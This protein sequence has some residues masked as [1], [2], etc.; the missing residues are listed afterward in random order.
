MAT[1]HTVQE[2]KKQLSEI[3]YDKL[4]LPIA[5]GIF[6]L[7]VLRNAWLAEDAFI[8]FRTVDNFIHGHGLRWNIAERVQTYTHPL[9]MLLISALY[10]ITRE[11][12]YTVIA[13]ATTTSLAA[14]AISC[15][16]LTTPPFNAALGL[17]LL[18]CSKAFIDF[19]TSGLENPLTHL[20]LA[21]FIAIYLTAERNERTLFRL[22]LAAGLA[23][24]NRMDT[25]L[26]LLPALCWVWWPQRGWH[27]AKSAL[28]GFAPF[29]CWPIFSLWYYGFPL[30]NTAYAKLN[31]GIPLSES[32]QRGI[33]FLSSSFELDP[34][35]LPAITLAILLPLAKRAWRDLPLSLG[36]ML[37][38]L[39]ILRIGGDFM[40]GRFL[41]APL[42]ISAVLIA[43]H[44]LRKPAHLT[45]AI[46]A[47]L[48]ASLATPRSPL[49]SGADYGRDIAEL[50][51]EYRISDERGIFYPHTGLLPLL[52][53]E[54]KKHWWATRSLQ[55]K[56][57]GSLQ[58]TTKEGFLV[59]PPSATGP[60][61]TT[62]MNI[63]LSGF[64]AGPDIHI[65]DAMALGD[66]LLARLPALANP[67]WGPGHFGRIMPEGY[68]ESLAQNSDNLTDR[69][70]A[71]YYD[72]LRHIVRGD[73][74][75]LNRLREIWRLNTGDYTHLID[76]QAYRFPSDLERSRS[77]LRIR[78]GDP[79]KHIDL[80]KALF[81]AKETEQALAALENA[82]RQNAL[83]AA[84][85]YLAAELCYTNGLYQP[86]V[87]VY[88]AAIDLAATTPAHNKALMYNGLGAS[89]EAL[90][91]TQE[92]VQ[93][94]M[95]AI[96]LDGANP[97]FYHNLAVLKLRRHDAEGAIAALR[98]AVI[99]GAD[100]E[101]ALLLGALLKRA[102]LNTET[103]QLYQRALAAPNLSATNRQA[104]T[105]Q[106]RTLQD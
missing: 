16:R 60:A 25:L 95:E 84:N 67:Q 29:L 47:L 73:L 78:P 19:S 2:N 74:F 104:L 55:V 36:L 65:I 90:H 11:M 92:A 9:W 3:S 91:R 37:Y 17:V 94:Y 96:E 38:L 97:I 49:R 56:K 44:T 75:S 23:T 99:R 27:S 32:I 76:R 18:T 88:L 22:A 12:P 26:L 13:L 53:G 7:V 66:P 51:D 8:T 61:I 79:L 31:T 35:T 58:E 71:T 105:D 15:Y 10:F 100:G 83:S 50:V 63:G 4:I 89:L 21:V 34:L 52:T 102:G 62:W 24:L 93:A 77:E 43:R 48:L 14:V 85:H 45:I 101:T 68:I 106:L 59:I 98:Q 87:E 1:L 86:A 103:R 6:A 57:R 72:K 46:A 42:L 80:A 54:A 81:A 40:A 33:W 41:S 39:Y 30:P 20:L 64:H 5:L 70:L 82:L 69:N 28:A